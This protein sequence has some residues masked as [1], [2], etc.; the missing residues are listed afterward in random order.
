MKEKEG[1]VAQPPKTAFFFSFFLEENIFFF[2]KFALLCAYRC[3]FLYFGFPA[4]PQYLS[5]FHSCSLSN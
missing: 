1:K 5:S 4:F 2:S 3:Y